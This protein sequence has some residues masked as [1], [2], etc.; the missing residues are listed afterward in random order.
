MKSIQVLSKIILLKDKRYFIISSDSNIKLDG[1]IKKLDNLIC[2]V[3]LTLYL[4]HAQIKHSF[5]C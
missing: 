4:K 5:S 1:L 2:L 3:S